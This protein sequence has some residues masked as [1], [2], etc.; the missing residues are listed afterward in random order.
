[1]AVGDLNPAVNASAARVKGYPEGATPIADGSGNVAAAAAVATLAAANNERAALAG[2]ELSGNG[3]TAGSTVE[4]T[5][6]GVIDGPIT[7]QL[8]VPAGAT[9]PVSMSKQFNPPLVG[10]ADGTDIVVTAPSLGAGNLKNQVYAWGY[11]V[12]GD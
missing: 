1:M 2:F 7:F 5:V 10:A 9:V 12:R 6:A 4:V 11:L 3:A 8:A